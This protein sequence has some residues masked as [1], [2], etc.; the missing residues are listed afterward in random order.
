MPMDDV[1]E[2]EKYLW[3]ESLQEANELAEEYSI[4]DVVV[5]HYT[6]PG[7]G[8]ITSEVSFIMSRREAGKY[9]DIEKYRKVPI[10][11]EEQTVPEGWEVIHHTSKE[12]ILVKR[13]K[14]GAADLEK[15]L[16]RVLNLA[17]DLRPPEKALTHIQNYIRTLLEE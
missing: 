15:H 17:E 4:K 7:N 6:Y 12:L 16:K 2:R 1:E 8:A 5:Q 11:E 14:S 10:T 9:D 3:V 13:R